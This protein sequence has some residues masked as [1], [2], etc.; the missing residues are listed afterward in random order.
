MLG[1]CGA[2]QVHLDSDGASMFVVFVALKGWVS[3]RDIGHRCA[4]E[5]FSRGREKVEAGPLDGEE[6]RRSWGWS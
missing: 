5:E 2:P 6:E 4:I 1:G 3:I